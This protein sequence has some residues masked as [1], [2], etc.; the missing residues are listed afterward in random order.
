MFFPCYGLLSIGI[1]AAVLGFMSVIADDP[2]RSRGAVGLREVFLNVHA[3][4]VVFYF[5]LAGMACRM[6]DR[7]FSQ[8]IKLSFAMIASLFSVFSIHHLGQ[9][10]AGWEV[11]AEH[12]L[13]QLMLMVSIAWFDPD[14]VMGPACIVAGML[15]VILHGISLVPE[16]S[17]AI[18][19]FEEPPL[20]QRAGPH[21]SEEPG[22]P[23]K[24]ADF[25]L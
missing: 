20:Q 2:K 6:G 1:S 7:G 9:R 25:P 24:A 13:S 10:Q 11:Q 4:L 3:L 18:S 23:E 22:V 19:E 21:G 16:G 15:S 17:F 8:W 5:P 12:L 14:S